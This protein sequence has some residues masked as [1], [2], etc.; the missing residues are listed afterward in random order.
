MDRSS[1]AN[2]ESLQAEITEILEAMHADG[3]LTTLSERYY[4][5]DLTK[6]VE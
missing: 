5:I 2:S 1:P 4:G 6:K 3:T